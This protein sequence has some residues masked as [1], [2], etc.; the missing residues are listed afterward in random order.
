LFITGCGKK[1]AGKSADAD[2]PG[3]AARTTDP[4]QHKVMSFNLEGLTEKGAKNWDVKGDSA[5]S[6]SETQVRLNKIE[7][8]A[9]GE[10]SQAVI[11]ADNGVY[12][13][14]KNNV[15]LENNVKATI[16]NTESGAKDFLDLPS[17]AKDTSKSKKTSTGTPKK[18]KTVITCDSDVLFDYQNNHVYFNKNVK[19]RSDDGAIDADRITINLDPVTRRIKEII[20]EGNVKM[21]RG[22]NVT[23]SDKA[24]YAESDKKVALTGKPKLVIYQEGGLQ[25]SLLGGSNASTGNAHSS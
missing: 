22:E 18:T 2:K 5:E 20:A 8:K 25:G 13:K 4:V 19:V 14:T 24:T 6:V 17:S 9:Y 7:A 15:T 21:V 11:T 12:D 16:V 23:Y 3:A 10:D 1:E